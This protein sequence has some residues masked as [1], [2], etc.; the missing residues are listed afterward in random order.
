MSI[1]RELHNAIT[2]SR[3]TLDRLPSDIAEA[4]ERLDF[5][6][7]VKV[8]CEASIT[9]AQRALEALG[10]VAELPPPGE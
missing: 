4:Q 8:E 9:E 2:S 7:H 6:N 1:E 3:Y 10:Y 5:L